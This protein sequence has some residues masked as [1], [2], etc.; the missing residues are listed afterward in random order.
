MIGD[1]SYFNELEDDVK[2]KVGL[3]IRNINQYN[4]AIDNE[5]PTFVHETGFCTQNLALSP[6][7]YM[8]EFETQCALCSSS[9]HITHDSEA[10]TLLMKDLKVQTH[11][12]EQVQQAINFVT[13]ESMQK[14]YKTHYRN[15][16]MLKHLIEVLSDDTIE[17]GRMVRFLTHSNS[18]RITNL[19]TKTVEERTLALADA[20][21]A[22]QAALDAK[23]VKNQDEA[24]NNFLGFLGSL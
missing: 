22:L 2:E 16:C 10:I 8:S 24:T 23:T 19:E 1:I 20:E 4:E 15:T 9:C 5:T 17:K 13:S 21:Q 11:N 14:W 7:T 12:L 18:I 6:C 3:R